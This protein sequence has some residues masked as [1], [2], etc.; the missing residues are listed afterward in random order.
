MR[1]QHRTRNRRSLSA[2]LGL[3]GMLLL[4]PRRAPAQNY[5]VPSF[6]FSSVAV[7]VPV[8]PTGDSPRLYSLQATA[9]QT[10]AAPAPQAGS[11]RPVVHSGFFQTGVKF[12]Y[13]GHIDLD[14]FLNLTPE[15]IDTVPVT[16]R[17]YSGFDNS[18]ADE[19]S[20]FTDRNGDFTVYTWTNPAPILGATTY[21]AGMGAKGSHWLR[22]RLTPTRPASP[23]GYPRGSFL[24]LNGDVDEDNGVD[25][26]DL[27]AL[28]D[29]YNTTPGSAGWNVNADL[30]GDGK[31][32]IFDLAILSENFQKLGDP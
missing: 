20:G 7:T 9:G 4:M 25:I 13:R 31:V 30:N 24:L 18:L 8:K 16:V 11:G 15:T 23:L 2:V 27:G 14:D 21:P 3:A 10:F 1:N 6:G 28:A 29:A 17:F 19:V 12:A 26:G 5:T 22:R 32:N